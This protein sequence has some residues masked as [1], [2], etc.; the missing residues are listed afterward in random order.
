MKQVHGIWLP[1]HEQHLL[2]FATKD[3]WTYQKNKL[4][5][6]MEYVKARRMAIDI[7][8]HVGLWSMHLEKMFDHVW[9]F[10]PIEDHIKCFRK[11]TEK[12]HLIGM[13]VGMN[14]ETVFIDTE[15]GSSGN[16]CVA[17]KGEATEMCRIDDL[18][19]EY[20]DFMKLD[21]EGYEW[22]ALNGAE[23]TIKRCR[24]V[25]IVEQKKDFATKYDLHPKQ[26]VQYLKGLGY[27]EK[28]VI[29]GDHI[30]VP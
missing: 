9:A 27:K 19:F 26:A 2:E 18:E 20:V 6:A 28:E 8:A 14:T 16:S 7:G 15:P 3:G 10:E 21:C 22:F 5:K 4:D 1:D 13:A 17:D 25:I 12:A 29:S 30:M 24:P 11:N 23:E